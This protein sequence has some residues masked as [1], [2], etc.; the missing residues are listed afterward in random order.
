VSRAPSTSFVLISIPENNFLRSRTHEALCCAI[1]SSLPL[2]SPHL[3][4]I[5][6]LEDVY[7][8]PSSFVVRDQVFI[9]IQNNM[10]NYPFCAVMF[11]FLDSRRV[12]KISGINGSR[13]KKRRVGAIDI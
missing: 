8:L 5:S 2:F 3:A 12:D 13:Q 10:Q 11:M 9:A 6:L 7:V 1:F 4:K